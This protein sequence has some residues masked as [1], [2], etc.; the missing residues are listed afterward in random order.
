MCGCN[1]RTLR[2][3][4]ELSADPPA[5]DRRADSELQSAACKA[6]ASA[7]KRR[8]TSSVATDQRCDDS[9]SALLLLN[10]RYRAIAV[11][12]KGPKAAFQSCHLTFPEADGRATVPGAR[13][14]RPHSQKRRE[15]T[16]TSHNIVQSVAT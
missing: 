9:M 11:S 4:D 7:L 8:C 15:I 2:L 6:A 12:L 3:H 1:N 5:A 14:Y 16:C 13:N 10:G